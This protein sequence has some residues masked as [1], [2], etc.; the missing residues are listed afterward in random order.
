MEK[1]G[2]MRLTMD[3]LP[4]TLFWH[5]TQTYGVLRGS[6]MKRLTALFALL[7]FVFVSGASFADCGGCPS[8]SPKDL[9]EDVAQ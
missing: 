4:F 8:P 3:I 2:H 6:L 5:H 9:Q 7:G 1:N